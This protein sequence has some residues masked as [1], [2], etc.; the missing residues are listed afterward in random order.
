LEELETGLL[1]L[2]AEGSTNHEIAEK[3]QISDESVDRHLAGLFAKI[4]ASS[5]ADATAVALKGGL[6]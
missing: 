3:L 6:M 4:G 1:R 5:R 2:L